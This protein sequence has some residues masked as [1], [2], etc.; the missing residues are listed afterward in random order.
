MD[1]LISEE[2]RFL[3]ELNTLYFEIGSTLDKLAQ[4]LKDIEFLSCDI[5]IILEEMNLI[6]HKM[7]L[8]LEEL[9]VSYRDMNMIELILEFKE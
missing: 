9:D 4:Q 1:L 8:S 2:G 7:N 5:K 3:R 6:L